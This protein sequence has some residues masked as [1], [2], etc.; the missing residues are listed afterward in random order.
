MV[1]CIVCSVVRPYLNGF[2]KLDFFAVWEG[3][4]W[5]MKD[6]IND[7]YLRGYEI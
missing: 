5:L 1:V 3:G 7:R 4:D 6:L 2:G